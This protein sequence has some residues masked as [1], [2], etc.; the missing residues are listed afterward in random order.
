MWYVSAADHLP[1]VMAQLTY[2]VVKL[3]EFLEQLPSSSPQQQTAVTKKSGIFLKRMKDNSVL[4]VPSE[5]ARK[6]AFLDVF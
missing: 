4:Q 1:K 5:P 3:G 2:F 6:S